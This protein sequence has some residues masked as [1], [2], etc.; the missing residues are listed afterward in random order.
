MQYNVCYTALFR[1]LES[2]MESIGNTGFAEDLLGDYGDW[3]CYYWSMKDLG[4]VGTL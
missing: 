1:D 2:L 3:G 4:Q